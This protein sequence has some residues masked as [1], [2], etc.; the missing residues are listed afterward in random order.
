MTKLQSSQ[1]ASA[2]YD[3]LQMPTAQ[4]HESVQDTRGA[5]TPDQAVGDDSGDL[6]GFRVHDFRRLMP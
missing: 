4:P 2:A 5:F 1:A 3:L 6:Q